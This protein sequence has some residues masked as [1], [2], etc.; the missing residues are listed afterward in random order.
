MHKEYPYAPIVEDPPVITGLAVISIAG[1]GIQVLA[2]RWR[3]F[4]R[5]QGLSN[6][7][8]LSVEVSDAMI[9]ERLG[10]K[11]LRLLD[12]STLLALLTS[13]EA[14]SDAKFDVNPIDPQRVAVCVGTAMG[15]PDSRWDF[16]RLALTEGIAAV[17]PATFPFT[18]G[19][20][21]ASQ[22]ALR[23]QLKGMNGSISAG[24]VSSLAALEWAILQLYTGRVDMAL[25]TASEAVGPAPAWGWQNIPELAA[26]PLADGAVSLVLERTSTARARGCSGYA[27][28]QDCSCGPDALE[29][30]SSNADAAIHGES[31]RIYANQAY[32]ERLEKAEGAAVVRNV[33]DTTPVTGN[34]VSTSGFM[35]MA[36]A[37]IDACPIKATSISPAGNPANDALE[38]RY[39]VCSCP[40]GYSGYSRLT[41]KG[42]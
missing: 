19:N 30:A 10:K 27:T 18:I 1:F 25:V 8:P 33:V 9:A 40:T 6:P 5:D 29:N 7:F 15:V 24:C 21:M 23:F 28:I 20:S 14:L 2:D 35:Q 37:I 11:G 38:S 26:V 36:C 3:E 16:Y 17:N 42:A 32:W 34:T 12:K 41:F 22:I 13:Q 4:Q 39:V 31:A